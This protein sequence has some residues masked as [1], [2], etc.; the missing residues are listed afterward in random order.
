LTKVKGFPTGLVN[1]T[2]TSFVAG[3]QKSFR[4]HEATS[5]PE[6]IPMAAAGRSTP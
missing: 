6:E 2:G 1:F 3:F 4:G 5:N